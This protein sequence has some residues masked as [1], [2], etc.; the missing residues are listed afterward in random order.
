MNPVTDTCHG[1]ASTMANVFLAAASAAAVVAGGVVLVGWAFDI[2]ALKSILPGWVSMK[3]NTAL[4]FI[5]IG[6]ALQFPEIPAARLGPR[7]SSHLLRLA[8]GCRWLAG[9]IGLLTL[10]EYLF[11]WNPGFDQWLFPEPAG[12]VATSNPGRMAP[13]TALCFLLLAAGASIAR[14]RL[15]TTATLMTSMVSGALVTILALAALLTYFTPVL[16]AFGWWGK[17]VMAVHTAILFA[18]LG[19]ASSMLAW[20]KSPSSWILSASNTFA[21]GLG[22]GLLVIVG[23]TTTRVQNLI[24]RINDSTAQ[25]ETMLYT[26]VELG[27]HVLDAQS[28]TRGYVLTGDEAMRTLQHSSV[29]DASKALHALSQIKATDPLPKAQLARIA[30]LATESL[31]WFGQV[32]AARQAAPGVDPALIRHGM[33]LTGA[34]REE[35]NQL[36]LVLE[37]IVRES[38]LAYQSASNFAYAV[39][40][41]GMVLSLIV[42]TLALLASNRAAFTRATAENRLRDE[43]TR[44]RQVTEFASDAIVTSDRAGNIVGWNRSAERMFGYAAAE[45]RLRPLT[46]LMPQRYRDPHAAGLSRVAAGAASKLVGKSIE[47]TGLRRDGSEFPLELSLTTWETGGLVYFSAFMR[48]LTERKRAEEELRTT[49]KRIH[50]QLEEKVQTRTAELLLARDAA[51]AAN[52]AKSTFLAN[53]SHELRTPLNAVLGF[54]SLMRRDSSLTEAQTKNLDIINRSGTHLLALI[55]DVLEIAKIEAGRTQLNNAPFDL[56]ALVREVTDMMDIRARD[57]GLQLLLDQ[58]SAFPRYINGDA[59]RLR[60]ILINLIGNAVKFTRQGGVS[61]RLRTKQNAVSHLIMEVE[62]SGPGIAAE[63]QQ[64]LFQ[65]FVQLGKQAADNQG[66]GLGL[67]ITRQ[68]VELMGGT[69]G[70]ESTPGKGSIFRV[71][72][73]LSEVAEGDIVAPHA[74]EQGEVTGLAPGQ[75]RHRILIVEDQLENQLLLSQL[76]QR[77]GFEVEVAGNG[78][79]GV[80]LFQSWQPQLIFMD[81]RMPVMDGLQASKAIRQLPG[82]RRVKIVAVTASVLTDDDDEM[83]AAGIDDIVRKPYRFNEIYASLTE[84]LGVQYVYAET[85]GDEETSLPVSL[86]AEML[87]VLPPALQGELR[88][89]LES[90]N[91]ERINAVLRQVEPIDEPLRKTLAHLADDFDYPAILKALRADQP[92]QPQQLDSPP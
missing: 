81:R 28:H 10:A 42:L 18:A 39:I 22:L 53:M 34:F 12:A 44:F 92:R 38:R 26:V 8:R 87:A 74:T 16:G 48:D 19:A 61:L 24:V 85:Q 37:Q 64:R 59:A 3:P 1:H 60:Q 76:M 75:T 14:L 41:A 43:E 63:D 54:S 65:P 31:Q 21:Y 71:A 35:I 89:A 25:V 83:L 91:S 79:Q 90:L 73:P 67:A 2:A 6:I 15:R 7:L 30:A 58:S 78:E 50:D 29:T 55:N 40:G 52:T 80:Q 32:V 46:L 82:G 77:I 13:E 47:L 69:I 27:A 62:D 88:D 68:F 72:L 23:L 66:T 56:G 49:E 11:D 4:A 86:T 45:V 9:L 17:T 51:E 33:Q 20:R 36:Q 57:K 84:H 5:L 70:V